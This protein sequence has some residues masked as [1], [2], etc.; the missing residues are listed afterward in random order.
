MPLSTGTSTPL[1]SP[2]LLPCAVGLGAGGEAGTQLIILAPMGSDY[3]ERTNLS[4]QLR[5][6]D[7]GQSSLQLR[8]KLRQEVANDGPRS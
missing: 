3:V 8:S 1:Y 2:L 6:A 7:R 5:F 4:S